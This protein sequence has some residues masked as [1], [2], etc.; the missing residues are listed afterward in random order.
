PTIAGRPLRISSPTLGGVCGGMSAVS[1]SGS[2]TTRSHSSPRRWIGEDEAR[3]TAH[4][5]R[6]AN[7][8]PE[9]PQ[10]LILFWLAHFDPWRMWVRSIGWNT[11]CRGCP[12]VWKV[13]INIAHM[14]RP[15]LRGGIPLRQHPDLEQI[16]HVPLRL[17]VAGG[18]PLHG[19]GGLIEPCLI[20]CLGG[21]F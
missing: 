2:R 4:L 15:S 1:R 11:T 8:S 14:R 17:G 9:Y 18:C 20:R 12:R 3:G 6:Q 13:W 5:R 21:E 10:C 19:Q 7:V 16:E